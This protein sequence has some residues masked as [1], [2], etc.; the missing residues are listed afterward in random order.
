MEAEVCRQPRGGSQETA[1]MTDQHITATA[2]LSL[3]ILSHT[4]L[5][6]ENMGDT[7]PKEDTTEEELGGSTLRRLPPLRRE[8][9]PAREERAVLRGLLSRVPLAV[10]E[11]LGAA[12]DE[13]TPEGTFAGKL[14]V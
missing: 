4:L 12:L 6:T 2:G 7:A 14:M 13:Q 5:E 8:P 11:E 3:E 10:A 1:E 9:E